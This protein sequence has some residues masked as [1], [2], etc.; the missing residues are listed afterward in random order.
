MQTWQYLNDVL[1]FRYYGFR[2]LYQS[3]AKAINFH[4]LGFY[5]FWLQPLWALYKVH[6]VEV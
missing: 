3:D 6:L 2:L 4:Q 1:T 5:L